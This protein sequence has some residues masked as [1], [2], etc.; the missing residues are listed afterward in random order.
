MEN[1][2]PDEIRHAHFKRCPECGLYVTVV[3]DLRVNVDAT[4]HKCKGVKK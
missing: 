4:I 3:R 2:S 1:L